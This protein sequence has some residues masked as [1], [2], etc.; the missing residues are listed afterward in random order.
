[1]SR[2][3]SWSSRVGEAWTHRDGTHTV[4]I[5]GDHAIARLVMLKRAGLDTEWVPYAEFDAEYVQAR[6]GE[7]GQ[8]LSPTRK[9]L[10]EEAERNAPAPYVKATPGEYCDKPCCSTRRAPATC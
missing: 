6:C 9:L 8:P 4:E 2:T 10:V 3:I 5:V 7:C 1:M